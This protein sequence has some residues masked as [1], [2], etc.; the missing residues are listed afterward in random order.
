VRFVTVTRE[1]GNFGTDDDLI[2]GRT[3][4]N[5]IWATLSRTQSLLLSQSVG[6]SCDINLYLCH[7]C[8]HS[9]VEL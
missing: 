3:L 8:P 5:I 9:F 6:E 2:H 7:M 4:R 1:K